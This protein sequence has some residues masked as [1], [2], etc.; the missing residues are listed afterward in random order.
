MILFFATLPII[1]LAIAQMAVT[2]FAYF[3]TKISMPNQI[4]GLKHKLQ[5]HF[6]HWRAMLITLYIVASAVALFLV[7][8]A[9]FPFSLA[10]F[11]SAML[12]AMLGGTNLGIPLFKS[13]LWFPL[14]PFCWFRPHHGLQTECKA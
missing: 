12:S 11:F 7:Y 1:L 8:A 10:Y 5:Q 3:S 14:L 2:A 6:A 9:P 4:D 13:L